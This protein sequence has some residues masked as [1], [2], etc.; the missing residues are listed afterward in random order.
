MSLV[1]LKGVAVSFGA[2]DVLTDVN[3]DVG[4]G[5]SIGLVG[6]NGAGKTTLL[7]VMAGSL[8]PTS[9]KRRAA[10]GLRNPVKS[11]PARASARGVPRLPDPTNRF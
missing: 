2:L 8:T 3:C 4:A 11:G 7:R 6:R 5:D 9:G 1:S 10:R